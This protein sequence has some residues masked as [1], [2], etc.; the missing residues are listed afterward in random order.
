MIYNASES[1]GASTVDLGFCRVFYR[2][3]DDARSF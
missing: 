3:F 2:G 1:G